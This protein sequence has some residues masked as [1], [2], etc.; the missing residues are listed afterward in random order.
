MLHLAPLSGDGEEGHPWGLA[1]HC[2]KMVLLL[3]VFA[4]RTRLPAVAGAAV[5]AAGVGTAAVAAA[6]AEIQVA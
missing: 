2:G 3:S 1:R 6:G 5:V 4:V